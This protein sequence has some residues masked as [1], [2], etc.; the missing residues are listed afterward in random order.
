MI[1]IFGISI[2][3]KIISLILTLVIG[4]VL[5]YIIKIILNNYFRIQMKRSKANIRRQ[6][7]LQSLSNNI[8]KYAFYIV[9]ILILLTILGVNAAALIASMGVIGLIIGLAC[10]DILKALLAGIFIIIEDQYA[11]G[12]IVEIA[13]FKG[14]VT[15]LGLKTTRITNDKGDIKMISNNNISDVINY[16]LKDIKRK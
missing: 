16:S 9:I 2:S 3:T 6:K 12:D 14:E 4:I 8:L 10:Q 7:T 15:S 13:G 1:E 5:Y 11:I